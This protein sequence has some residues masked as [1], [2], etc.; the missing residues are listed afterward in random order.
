MKEEWKQSV[1]NQ[2]EKY[3]LHIHYEVFYVPE[4]VSCI[5]YTIQDSMQR[6]HFCEVKEMCRRQAKT[7]NIHHR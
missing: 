2:L 6:S 5:Y 3:A 1:K 4:F 7:Y